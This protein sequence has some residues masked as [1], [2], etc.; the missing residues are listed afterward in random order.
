M[1]FPL[2]NSAI[3]GA[4][5]SACL[6]INNTYAGIIFSEDFSG[7]S[8][9]LEN[10][11]IVDWQDSTGGD[12][13]VYTT[14]GAAARGMS[15]MYDHDNNPATAEVVLPGGLEVNDNSGDVF[16]T[17]TFSLDSTINANQLG[18]LSFFGGM[19]SGNAIGATIEIFNLTENISLTGVLAPTLGSFNWVYNEFNFSSTAAS[20]GDQIQFRWEGGGTN[21]ANGQE[22]ALVSFSIIDAPS[23]SVSVPEPFILAIFSIGIIGL[24]L[25]RFNK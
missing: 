20:I 22:V 15:G 5:F 17:A 7:L 10:S 25:H 3:V 12:F 23:V 21:S 6:L 1:R 2:I 24:A 19:R 16:L 8:T 4:T 11:L 18:S 9:A 14:G 13:E